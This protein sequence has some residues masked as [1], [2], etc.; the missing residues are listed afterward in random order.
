MTITQRGFDRVASSTN[1]RVTPQQRELIQALNRGQKLYVTDI[2][3]V[4]PDNKP[5][6]IPPVIITIN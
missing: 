6:K 4:G 3:A 5:S 2:W 1:N